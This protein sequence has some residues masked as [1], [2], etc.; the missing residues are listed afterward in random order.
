MN[1]RRIAGFP[2]VGALVLLGFALFGTSGTSAQSGTPSNVNVDLLVAYTPGAAALY[3]GGVATRINH[4]LSVANRAYADSEVG[5]TLRLAQAVQVSYSDTVNTNTA[6][7]AFQQNASP[8]FTNVQ[9]WRTQYGADMAVLL[10]PYCGDGIAGL[11][12]LGGMGQHGDLASSKPWMYTHVALNTDD[13]VLAHELGHNMGLVHS[14]KQDPNGGTFSYSAGYGVQGVMVDVMAYSSAFGVTNAQKV[15]QFSSPLHVVNG[16]TFG[17]SQSNATQGADAAASLNSVRAAVAGFY[18]SKAFV[19]SRVGSLGGDT[20]SDLLRSDPDDGKHYV[21][22]TGNC[23]APAS[24]FGVELEAT[25]AP[26]YRL[27]ACGDWDGDGLS[28]AIFRGSDGTNL[29]WMLGSGTPT[30]VTYPTLAGSYWTV[31]GAGDLDGDGDADLVWRNGWNGTNCVWLMN[32]TSAP[33]SVALT[34]VADVKW[35]IE[36]LG[37]FDGDGKQD[38]FWRNYGSGKN[39]VWLMDGAS[40]RSTTA[41]AVVADLNWKAVGC[42]DFDGDGHDD[43]LFNHAGSGANTL[44][45]MNGPLVAHTQALPAQASTAWKC[46]GIGDFDGDGRRDDIV[47][48]DAANE[49]DQLWLMNG[50]AP[51]SELSL[52][53][54]KDVLDGLQA[55]ADLDGDGRSELVWRNSGSG[56]NSVWELGGA[57]VSSTSAIDSLAGSTQRIAR[58]GDFDGDGK[59]DLL[60]RDATSGQVK[61]WLMNGTTVSA[62]SD[63]TTVADANNAIVGVGDL[64]GDGKDDIVLRHATSGVN[65]LWLMNGGAIQSALALPTVA[66]AN[67]KIAG[68]ADVNAD[69]KADLVWRNGSNGNDTFW[70]MN[71]ATRT[72]NVPFAA[73]TDLQ[74]KLVGVGDFDGDGKPDLLW[75]HGTSGK[76]S[77]WFLNGTSVARTA[78]TTARPDLNWVV[79]GL[80]DFDA[81]GRADIAWRNTSTRARSLWLM[82]GSSL[83][84]S[85]AI[86]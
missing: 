22:L 56:A 27:Q 67:W 82:N 48:N 26:I 31:A 57:F 75:R 23:S 61:V 58:A 25:L 41:L 37:D 59:Q 36:A 71:G 14:R 29:G 50:A 4:M 68:V 40:V 85:G 6:L 65:T 35:R 60:W 63:V 49:E 32:G 51:V 12:Y 83:T 3:S 79:E 2:S 53:T 73:V 74:W 54:G 86:Y 77:I 45:Y 42:G 62:K 8:A 16:L 47:W 1:T 5:I 84:A 52:K 55:I 28:D 64:N 76:N 24:G 38:L 81:D 17:V 19:T 69:G 21:W 34:T 10:R 46:T 20:R 43:V 72:S 44:W 11:G 13:Y 18:P 78:L 7:A 30:P 15:Y 70:L 80:G 9:S 33:T 39:S 66:D